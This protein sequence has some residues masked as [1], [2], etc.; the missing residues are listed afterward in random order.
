MFGSKKKVAGAPKIATA[1]KLAAMDPREMQARLK[2]FKTM[3]GKS[4]VDI[5][6]LEKEVRAQ[7]APTLRREMEKE[8][9]LVKKAQVRR[10]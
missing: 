8:L 6:R 4:T 5:K 2:K 1:G 9:N 7:K 3:A 10:K